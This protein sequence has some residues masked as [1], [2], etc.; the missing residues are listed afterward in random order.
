M[1]GVTP[2]AS[3]CEP[4]RD[5]IES[6]PQKTEEIVQTFLAV[7][8][9]EID[10]HRAWV[11]EQWNALRPHSTGVYANFISDEGAAGV[12]A[13]YGDRL[14]RLTAVHLHAPHLDGRHGW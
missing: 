5:L 8:R 2:G 3:A 4:F 9:F 7:K 10:R 6:A 13:A 11:R 14:R 1:A 12:E